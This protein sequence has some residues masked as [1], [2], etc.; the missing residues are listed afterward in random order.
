[1]EDRITP[2]LWLETSG[3]EPAD[4]AT[5]VALGP[6]V[7]RATWWRN[8]CANRTDL[9]R[10][11]PEFTTLGLFELDDGLVPPEGREGW[12]FRHYPRP[13]Q[14]VLTGKPTVGLS[15]VLISPR[16]PEGAQSLRD[17]GD[18]VHIRHIAEA[19][20][21]GM[22][23]IT[24]Y[25]RIGGGAGPRFL[26]LYEMTDP[27]AEA[28]FKAMPGHVQARLGPPG[29]PAYNEWAWHPALWINYVNSF[30]LAGSTDA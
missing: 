17:W 25:E 30:R 26:H 12:L 16:S 8:L 27:D 28:V 14:G 15:V 18:F 21:P 1:M 19:A 4:Y 2:G 9:P 29:T 3:A 5:T 10:D 24:P 13:G 7:R 6:G 23:M 11:V 20:V 22:G